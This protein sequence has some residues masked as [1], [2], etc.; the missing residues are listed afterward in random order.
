MKHLNK[1]LLIIILIV[2]VYVVRLKPALSSKISKSHLPKIVCIG[3]SNTS[4]TI[5]AS[6][7]AI[8]NTNIRDQFNIINMGRNFDTTNNVLDKMDNIIS[9]NA[10]IYILLIGTND[11]INYLY[12]KNKT[13]RRDFATNITSIIKSIKNNTTSQLLLLTLPIL[14]ED[15]DSKENKIVDEFNDIIKKNSIRE[16]LQL[17]DI[18]ASMKLYLKSKKNKNKNPLQYK[19]SRY[20]LIISATLHYIFGLQWNTIS[21]IFHNELTTDSIHMNNT[22]A[23]I[24]Y[25]EI[26]KF[27]HK[28]KYVKK[29]QLYLESNI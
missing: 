11:V 5:A 15:L 17:V 23:A 29:N 9:Y 26:M 3:D 22:A 27:I 18:N 25:E 16:G 4:G 2:S 13:A 12:A 24:I 6:Y 28:L 20:A 10:D 14:G 7:T 21:R 19:R 1:I 8:M